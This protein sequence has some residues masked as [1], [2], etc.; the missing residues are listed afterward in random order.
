MKL[1]PDFPTLSVGGNHFDF[2]YDVIVKLFEFFCRDPIFRKGRRTHTLLFI[3]GQKAASTSKRAIWP[4]SPSLA[5]IPV[6]SRARL[7]RLFRPLGIFHFQNLGL[8]LLQL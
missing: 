2:A 1:L 7:T 6:Q 5:C 8:L 3:P 4:S